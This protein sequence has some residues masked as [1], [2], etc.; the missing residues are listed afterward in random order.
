MIKKIW[1][2]AF[3]R[4]S[5]IFFVGSMV[6]NVLN[7]FFH[8]V[9]GRMVSVEIYGEVESLLS[10]VN[11]I[12]VPSLAIGMVATKF[13]AGYKADNDPVSNYRIMEYLNR[14]VLRWGLPV[15]FMMVLVTPL[16]ARF[17]KIDQNL[18]LVIVWLIMYLSFLLAI[19]NG[20]I[21]GWQKF[22]EASWSTF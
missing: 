18:P 8:V 1:G 10:L 9:L 11:I 21:S 4:N 2:N 6:V 13:S 7:Y 19:T 17:L 5:L 16:V 20:I 12:S 15:F 3:A 14:K 22:Y